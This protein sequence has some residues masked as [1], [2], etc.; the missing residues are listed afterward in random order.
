MTS[1]GP[2]TQSIQRGA[3]LGVSEAEVFA[4]MF[5]K[6][7]ELLSRTPASVEQ[8]L[9]SALAL[10]RQERVAAVLGGSDDAAAEALQRAAREASGLFL[11]VGAISG[12]LR[13]ELLDRRTVHVHPGVEA[14]VNAAGLWLIEH[15]KRT[16]WGLLVAESAFGAEVEASATT[17]AKRRSAQVVQRASAPR[18]SA[19]WPAA[20]ARLREAQ[21]D[22]VLVGLEPEPVRAFL[23]NWRAAGLS[24]ELAVVAS[25]PHYA[26]GAAPATLA[27]AWPLVWHGS[28]ERYSARELNGRFRRRFE[29]PLDGAAWAAWAAV[30]IVTE[31]AVRAGSLGV[32]PVLDFVETRLAFDGH[33]GAALSFRESDRE[34]GQPLYIARPRPGIETGSA[35]GLEIVAEVSREKLDAVAQRRQ[36]PAESRE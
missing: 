33:K 7:V 4:N 21:V 30:K 3:A 1:E 31:A 19:D 14:L 23:D 12:R 22:A 10:F 24:G 29:Q 34:L 5:G 15:A 36:A 8:T 20:L 9:E 2:L 28:L 17:L 16:R 11:N 26:L 32:Q 27:G 18:A 25:D 6:R 35:E 13:G